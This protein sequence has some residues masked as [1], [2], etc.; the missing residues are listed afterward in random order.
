MEN[1]QKFQNQR[2]CNFNLFSIEIHDSQSVKD[3]FLS[4]A[5]SPKKFGLGVPRAK[6]I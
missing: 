5:T 1:S 3:A 4:T 6:T 2:H